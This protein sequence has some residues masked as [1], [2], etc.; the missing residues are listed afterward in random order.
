LK[1]TEKIR[2]IF[3]TSCNNHFHC[4]KYFRNFL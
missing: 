2:N 1:Y 4:S 3:W